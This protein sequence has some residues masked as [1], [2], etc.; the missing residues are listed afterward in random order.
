MTIPVQCPHCESEFHLSPDLLGKSMRCPNPD[1]R[2]VFEV[3][4]AGQPTAEAPPT[5]SV[6]VVPSTG[7]VSDFV[8]VLEG[9]ESGPAPGVL[10]YARVDAGEVPAAEAIDD[11]SFP[12]AAFFQKAQPLP[13]VQVAV[14]I[15]GPKEVAWSGDAPP[16]P[17]AAPRPVSA[18]VATS[19]EDEEDEDNPL[20][21]RRRKRGLNVAKLILLGIGGIVVV[22]GLGAVVMLYYNV[23]Q[24]EEKMAKEAKDTYD[25]GNYGASQQ[26]YLDV[27]AA[28][29]GS[30]DAERYK[31][32][33][34]LSETRA[35][36]GAV[37]AKENPEPSKKKFEEFLVDYG[38]HPLAQ[39]DTG[40][41]AD[42]LDTGGRLLDN[43]G[44]HGHDRLK[45]YRSEL[46][47]RKTN[48]AE[49]AAADADVAE[50]NR[51]VPV[52][53]KYRGKEGPT[54]EQQQ[55]KLTELAQAI[56]TERHRLAVL[57]PF[58]NLADDPTAESI[59]KF[60]V[61]LRDN[62]L[63]NDAEANYMRDEAERRLRQLIGP[64]KSL[65]AADKAPFDRYPPVLFA[66]PVAGSPIPRPTP[67]AA[68]DVVFAVV[69]GVLYALDAETGTLLWGTRVAPPTADPRGVDLPVRVNAG[70]A[71]WVLVTGEWEGVPGL[72]A[73]VARTG[74]AVWHQTLRIGAASRPVIVGGRAY[75]PLRDS[76]GTVAEFEIVTGNR[77]TDLS[78][79]QPIGGGVAMMPGQFPG[80][81]FLFVPGDTR[82]TFVF[83]IGKEDAQGKRLE[84]A[85]VRVFETNHPKDSL[86]GEP[87]LVVPADAEGPRY[88]ILSQADG[89][90]TMRLRAFPLPPPDKLAVDLNANVPTPTASEVIVAGWSWFPP[91]SDGERLVLATD[92]GAF[93]AFG[94]NQLGNLDRALFDIPV[95]KPAEV[96]NGVARSLVVS[97][98]EDSYWAVLNGQLVRLRTAVKQEGGLRIAVQGDPRAVGEPVHRAQIRPDLGLGVVVARDGP[99]ANAQAVA[100]DLQTGQVKWQRR[101]GVT[102]AAPPIAQANGS[103]LVVDEDGGVYSVVGT[104]GTPGQTSVIAPPFGELTGRAA[105]CSSPDG[106]LVWVVVAEANQTGR[107]ARVRLIVDG[108]LKEN[109]VVELTD[110][111]AGPPVALGNAIL[112]PAANGFVYRFAPGDKQF[113]AGPLWRGDAGAGEAMCHIGSVGADEFLVTDGNRKFTR[114]KWS[115]GGKAEKTG[116]PWEMR[117]KIATPPTALGGKG[118][119]LAADAAGVVF[120]FDA[121]KPGDPIRRWVG[122]PDGAIPAGAPSDHFVL[123]TANNKTLA[124]YCVDHRHLIAID[125]DAAEPAWVARDLVPV[126]SGELAGWAVDRGRLTATDQ[127]GRAMQFDAATGA[128]AADIPLPNGI[129][130]AAGP[131]V[132]GDATRG[133][134]VV[135]DGTGLFVDLAPK[136]PGSK[137]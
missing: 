117:A 63:Q 59:E 101:L 88:F 128:R 131:V 31:F 73:R 77:T 125:P 90:A 114:W 61:A 85:C 83:E 25:S 32:F 19:D 2:E 17:F 84:P 96:A 53:N 22:L 45:V 28:Y 55:K 39:P 5:E 62:N 91:T 51:I 27:L 65:I 120:L 89:P 64:R 137:K 80:Q 20:A 100:F 47:K 99:A 87:L 105:V 10:T 1:C 124:I 30:S 92:A 106:R 12:A 9:E 129:G 132:P 76:L 126:E 68:P 56:A 70:G 42:V 133:L 58:R 97:A 29:P 41:G 52:V 49:L 109:S 48:E 75:L 136:P 104:P 4:S 67:D 34:T 123:H 118:Q 43:I 8:P 7:Q 38:A 115:S 3:R 35:V 79:R 82:R 18:P 16:D 119:I 13:K 14:P 93:L 130:V 24:S 108:V 36:V 66:S 102:P 50:G 98:D 103:W 116:G 86:R 110:Q 127:T 72:T 112:L 135:G 60:N 122:G 111:P 40:Y 37:T 33:A 23:K 26:K 69:R 71:D 6:A 113:S 94:V 95:P 78:I 46:Q 81:F 121:E 57:A 107:R 74:E 15:G 44:D 134:I 54:L 21:R 11:E